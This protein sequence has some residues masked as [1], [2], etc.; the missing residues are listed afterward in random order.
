MRN[1][2]NENE[3]NEI[4]AWRATELKEL[5]TIDG[6]EAEFVHRHE[7]PRPEKKTPALEF[8]T[9]LHRWVILNKQDFVMAQY[10][11]RTSEGKRER[12]QAAKRGLR[13]VS[14]YEYDRLS[15]CHGRAQ[16]VLDAAG[17]SH[18]FKY[19]ELALTAD[20]GGLAVKAKLDMG[21]DAEVVDLKT[22]SKWPHEGRF[23][24][25]IDKY[26]YD[27]SACHYLKVAELNGLSFEKYRWLFVESVWP[28]RTRLVTAPDW[29]IENTWHRLEEC[30][31]RAR[32]ID[33][34]EPPIEVEL[35]PEEWW[36]FDNK[37]HTALDGV[38]D[39]EE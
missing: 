28:Y 32:A 25:H 35:Q 30:Y 21:T 12:E 7:N 4:E 29:L 10:D 6:W 14:K 36:M 34:F 38:E 8:G 27:V 13:V 1:Q 15:R 31:E 39:Y 11:G 33:F 26:S 5:Q 22:I 19:R 2:C 16:M 3:Y 9:S 17:Y 23:L 20:I 24:R 37:N 18:P